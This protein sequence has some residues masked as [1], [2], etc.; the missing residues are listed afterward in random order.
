[1]KSTLLTACIVLIGLSSTTAQAQPVGL[2]L[3]L[4]VDVS[5]SVDDARFTLQR[6]GY[7][8]AFLDPS[9]QAAIASGR[10]VAVTLI[11]W[12]TFA[13]T[14]VPWTLLDSAASATSFAAAVGSAVRPSGIGMETAPGT[15]L[16]FATPLFFDNAFVGSRRIIDVSG[17]GRE[18]VGFST[19][20]ARDAALAQG[21]DQ[22]NGLPILGDFGV[23]DFYRTD[24]QGGT[25]SFTQPANGFADF[26][27]AVRTK[28]GREIVG[29]IPEP[30]TYALIGLGLGVIGWLSRRRSKRVD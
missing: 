19:S 29:D 22:I 21:V 2:E 3:E 13:T 23:L 12:S 6:Q 10:S 1:M 25:G 14:A 28:I 7:V 27:A 11:Y 30:S 20:A 18:N 5:G 8:D 4:L 26:G 15:A 16:N 9:V 24:I 17:D